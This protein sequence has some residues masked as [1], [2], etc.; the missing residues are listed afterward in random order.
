V[1]NC[2]LNN[3]MMD[4]W[5]C[6]MSDASSSP[7]DD[8]KDP[9]LDKQVKDFAEEIEH[10]G[11]KAGKQLERGVK[12][13]GEELGG[14]GKRLE[15]SGK[16]MQSWFDRTFG[17]M[18]P[19][20]VSFLALIVLVLII[21]LFKVTAESSPVTG[22]IGRF[23]SDTIAL[24]FVLMLFFS[25]SA[26]FT[27]RYAS[28]F[29]WVAPLCS[30][31]GLVLVVWI[32]LELFQIFGFFGVSFFESSGNWLLQNIVVLFI[33]ILVVG[34]LLFFW[35]LF[36]K[37]GLPAQLSPVDR[38]KEHGV[39]ESGEYKPLYRSGKQRLLGGVCG[40]IAEYFQLD[41]WLIRI[42]WIVG[43]FVTMGFFVL[44]YVICWLMIPRN[45]NHQ[46][47]T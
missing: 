25:Y 44:V 42:L 39:S 31:L 5:G 6:C 32:L 40:G 45:P 26:Y 23:L 4:T 1:T 35:T 43:L 34:Y 47:F 2:F 7:Q 18:G 13:I 46:W 21:Q 33:L 37:H 24:L 3:I 27:R 28:S 30:A 22:E 12:N 15:T 36:V 11:K 17:L 20:L 16:D 9:S 38:K 29:R 10:L 19:F 41:P 8:K 14:M